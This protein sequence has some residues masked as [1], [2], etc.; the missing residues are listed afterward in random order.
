MHQNV[1]AI[2]RF[3]WR[4]VCEGGDIRTTMNL[5]GG[6]L[7]DT[8]REYNGKVVRMA[9]RASQLTP[10]LTLDPLS[11][12]IIGAASGGRTHDIRSHS[13]AFCH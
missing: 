9:L 7:D 8:M 12:C 6:A 2:F 13:P 5:Y 1:V 11:C 10:D 3:R 4:S